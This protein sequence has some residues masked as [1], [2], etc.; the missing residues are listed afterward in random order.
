MIKKFVMIIMVM[1]A[2]VLPCMADINAK[3]LNPRNIKTYIPP[4]HK[5]SLMMR[6]AFAEWSR[7]TKN[8][9]IF[10]YVSN[11]SSADVKV[12]FVKKIDPKGVK[13]LDKAIG[14]THYETHGNRIFGAKIEI[15][16]KTQGGGA[17]SKDEIYTT[18]LHEIGHSIGLNHSKNNKCIM[19]PQARVVMEICD[20]DLN[21]LKK[22]YPNK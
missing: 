17:L 16:D 22:L 4:N 20:E 14:V 5:N 1:I 13:K 10:K 11:P 7:M 2:F 6:H 12:Y 19:Y 8:R 15:A 18:M 9:V 21:N 3:W